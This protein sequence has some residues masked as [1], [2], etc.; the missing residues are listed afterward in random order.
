ML[1]HGAGFSASVLLNP[2]SS[3]IDG[4][5]RRSSIT[6]AVAVAAAGSCVQSSRDPLHFPEYGLSVSSR[7]T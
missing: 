5:S 7:A 2:S 1:V 4:P 6:D 3:A